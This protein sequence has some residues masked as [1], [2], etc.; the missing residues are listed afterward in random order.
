MPTKNLA[1]GTNAKGERCQKVLP[2]CRTCIVAEVVYN[3]MALTR[4]EG[5]APRLTC[6]AS[7]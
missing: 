1:V 4:G 5:A 7:L 3:G 6:F 2:P